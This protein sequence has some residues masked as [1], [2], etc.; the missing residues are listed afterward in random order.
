MAGIELLLLRHGI[1]EERRSGLDDEARNLTAEGRLRT[2][3]VLRRARI[4]DLDVQFLFSS[5]LTRA[6]R[7]TVSVRTRPS[8]V[9]LRASSSS[10]LRSSSAMPWRSNSSSIPAMVPP[11]PAGR[12]KLQLTM[13]HHRPILRLK[14]QG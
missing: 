7:R 13:K 8:A 14:G 5:P 3:A 6:R 10:P 11:G 12:L 4:L 1:A 2:E 9:R